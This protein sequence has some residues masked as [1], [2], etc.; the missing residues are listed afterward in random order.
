MKPIQIIFLI[1]PEVHLLDLAGA[2]Q[3]FLEAKDYGL[4]I[5]VSY[6]SYG[7]P[8]QTSTGIGLENIQHFSEIKAS[9][10]DYVIIPGAALG[11]LNSPEMSRQQELFRWI[12]DCYDNKANVC[13]IC[14]G[15][16]F[17][18]MAGLLDGKRCTTHWKR[19]A[20]LQQQ[21]PKLQVVDNILFTEDERIFTSAGVT[22]GI[23]LA[24]YIVAKIKD[25]LL[26]YKVAR[27]LVVYNR[28][29][30]NDAQQSVHLQ[31]RNHIHI[32][33][34]KI[35]DWLQEKIDTKMILDDLADVACM[36][37]R[38]M[39]RVFKKET[40]ITINDYIQL[41]R[42]EKIRELLKNPDLSRRDIALQCGLKSERQVSRIL[43]N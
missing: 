41:L 30:G 4:D 10:G 31:Y 42:K 12:N 21:Y 13:S 2:D 36:S 1:L 24:L 14:T 34:H 33:V 9:Q 18:A 23:D 3:V 32:G 26:S 16:F 35:Q 40:G 37:T 19:T 20:E 7:V 22:S 38:N 6:C 17:L 11:F 29:A 5:D 15:S 28:R 43:H 8:I 39:T 25:D 27:E